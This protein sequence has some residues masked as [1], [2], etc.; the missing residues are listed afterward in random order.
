MRKLKGI[1]V[2]LAFLILSLVISGC[3]TP[4]KDERAKPENRLQ[5]PIE[6]EDGKAPGQLGKVKLVMPVT[7]INISYAPFVVAKS[8]GYFQEEGLDVDLVP[9]SGSNDATIQVAAGNAEF[10]FASP[11]AGIIGLQKGFGMNIRFVYQVNRQSIWSLSVLPDSPIRS[12]ADLKGKTIGVSAMGS[13]GVPYARAY[14]AAAGLDPDKDIKFLAIGVG[15]QA[16]TAI[17]EKKVDAIA[18]WDHMLALFETM[19]AKMRELPVSE[20]I[21]NTPDAA[22][23][24]RTDYLEEYPEKVVG[25]SRAVAKGFE[26]TFANPEAAVKI[27][28][29]K[30]PEQGPAAGKELEQLADDT[31]VLKS[32]FKYSNVDAVPGNKWGYFVDQEWKEFVI[33]LLDQ[34]MLSEQVPVEKIYTNEFID[35]ANKFDR[36]K[37][38][39]Q[40]KEYR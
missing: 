39:S 37:V 5:S 14:V 1:T 38:V 4:A 2:L 21:K 10:G 29:E 30:Y 33:F 24:V 11:A 16:L 20:K 8:L 19:D 7:N 18:F 35:E 22:I 15:S 13:S 40:A 3:S 27:F 25:L 17:R 31:F 9:S 36:E 34:A 26:F 23:V 12:L 6:A 32:R 28:W